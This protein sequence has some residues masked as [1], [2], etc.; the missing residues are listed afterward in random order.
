ML[1]LGR[2][3]PWKTVSSHLKGL[4]QTF[5]PATMWFVL[6]LIPLPGSCSLSGLLLKPFPLGDFS[7]QLEIYTLIIA[8]HID[9]IG[10]RSC[11]ARDPLSVTPF[12]VSYTPFIELS[13]YTPLPRRGVLWGGVLWVGR[14]VV[15]QHK[16]WLWMRLLCSQFTYNYWLCLPLCIVNLIKVARLD[17]FRGIP[18][19]FEC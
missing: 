16:D 7:C 10:M 4:N 17:S 13:L 9:V 2:Y 12:L 11:V 15:W 14:S 5:L 19:R 1:K 18:P 8:F 3:W 6:N